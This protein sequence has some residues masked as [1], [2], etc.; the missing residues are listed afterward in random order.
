MSST[1]RRALGSSLLRLK[2]MLGRR[3]RQLLPGCSALARSNA[4]AASAAGAV[5]RK[6]REEEGHGS[7]ANAVRPRLAQLRNRL[8]SD[9][10]VS[11]VEFAG[12]PSAAAPAK[13]PCGSGSGTVVEAGNTY[14][15]V[16]AQI[17]AAAA[18][19][20]EVNVQDA[21]SQAVLQ[22]TFGRQHSYLR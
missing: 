6:L 21:R 19:Y 8:Q 1:A 7:S 4:A 9:V 20:P 15:R 10:P 2:P 12:A 22:D 18:A 11:P 3:C 14:S 17:A 16:R 5:R 13:G